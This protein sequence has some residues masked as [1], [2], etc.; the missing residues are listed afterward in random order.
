MASYRDYNPSKH[1]D[2]MTPKYLFEEI[3][4]LIPVDKVIS[5]PFYGDGKC[6]KYLEEMGFDV[7]HQQEDFW[8]NDRGDVVIDNPPFEHKGKIIEELIKRNKPFM[9]ILPV[10]TI[11]YNY[12]KILKD[13]LQICIPKRRPKFI[14]YDKATGKCDP[15]WKSKNSAFDCIWVCWKMNFDNDIN[16]L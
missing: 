15:D 10:S 3:K 12:S 4:D 13:G 16:F 6:G 2:F 1:N 5:M 7:I 9:L 11:C 8:E 14:Y